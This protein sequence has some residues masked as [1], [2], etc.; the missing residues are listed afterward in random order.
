MPDRLAALDA[1]LALCDNRD[2]MSLSR[3]STMLD[4]KA[5]SSAECPPSTSGANSSR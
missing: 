4:A 1:V 3:V 2:R 5:R